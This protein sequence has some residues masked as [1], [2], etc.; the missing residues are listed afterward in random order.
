MRA[1]YS[2]D[3]WTCPA[4]HEVN[5]DL[6]EQAKRYREVL[7]RAAQSDRVVRDN[8]EDWAERIGVLCW[9]E[10]STFD[11][12]SEKL[13]MTK[14][15]RGRVISIG[16][17]LARPYQVSMGVGASPR[18]VMHALCGPISSPWTT[19]FMR[20]LSWCNV[21]NGSPNLTMLLLGTCVRLQRSRGGS[22]LNLTFSSMRWRKSWANT[23]SLE[24]SSKMARG[25]KRRLSMGSRNG[26]PY[27]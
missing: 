10:V 6:T 12:G 19:L 27:S 23:T 13:R 20:G 18:R 17:S 16:S 25:D 3:V 14:G 22:K 9:D 26:T 7:D 2:A 5:K 4:S 24:R 8:W 11:P 15:P 21:F 1:A